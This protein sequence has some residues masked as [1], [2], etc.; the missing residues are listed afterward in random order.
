[1][2]DRAF[3]DSSCVVAI[4]LDERNSS[5]MASRIRRFASVSAHPLLDAEVRSACARDDAP[6]PARELERI[7]WIDAPRP[8]SAEIDRVLAA[9]YLRGADALHLATALYLEPRPRSLTFL[10]LDVRQRAVAKKLGFKV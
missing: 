4:A 8:L 1:M 5:A 3:I 10:T 9:G 2:T 6:L 7:S